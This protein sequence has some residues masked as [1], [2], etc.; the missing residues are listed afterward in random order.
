MEPKQ[1]LTNIEAAAYIGV[2]PHTLEMW[3]SNKRYD[4]PYIK[5]GHLV[6][7]RRTALDAWLERR[8]LTPETAAL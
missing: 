6:K 2:S 4:I 3:R 8:T 1:I 5:V 7:Y